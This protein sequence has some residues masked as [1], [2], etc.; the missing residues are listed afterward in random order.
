MPPGEASTRSWPRALLLVG[1]VLLVARVGTSIYQARLPPPPSLVRWVPLEAAEARA[2]AEKKPILYEFSASWCGPCQAMEREVFADR[3][4]ADLINGRFVPVR[5]T[6]QDDGSRPDALRRLYGA[7]SIPLLIV[8]REQ[9]VE[10]SVGYTSKRTTMG[11][12]RRTS[13]K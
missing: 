9:V 4:A 10:R 13:G 2:A 8:A 6:D 7:S 1:A 12:L 3:E 11:F 5:I